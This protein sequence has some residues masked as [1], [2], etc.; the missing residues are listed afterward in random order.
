MTGEPPPPVLAVGAVIELPS[1]SDPAELSDGFLLLVRRGHPPGEGKWSLP[2]GR[3]EAGETLEGAVA[4]EVREETGLEVV[5]GDLVGWVERSGAGY[6]FVI[7]DFRARLVS[8]GEGEAGTPTGA[9]SGPDVPLAAGDDAS[10]AAFVPKTGLSELD[11]VEGLLDF[12]VEHGIV[13][14][15]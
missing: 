6:H 11:L 14:T 5:V 8:A 7:V 4:R 10:E 9:R 15:R 1:G 3:V 13:G 12:L 2:G